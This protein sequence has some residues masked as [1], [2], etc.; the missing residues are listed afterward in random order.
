MDSN[1]NLRRTARRAR[2]N[3]ESAAHD[4]L[5]E[6]HRTE[7]AR[8]MADPDLGDEERERLNRQLLME[9]GRR[10]LKATRK[11]KRDNTLPKLIGRQVKAE[12][13]AE[14]I[15]AGRSPYWPDK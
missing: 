9:Y 14:R 4:D 3:A 12:I 7:K 6:W 10:S 13:D 15:A 1:E 8:I 2:R 11:A 5:L